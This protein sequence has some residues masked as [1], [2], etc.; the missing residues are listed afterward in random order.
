MG[1]RILAGELEPGKFFSFVG[2]VL[3]LYQPVKQLGR[4]G[5]IAL[6][7]AAAGE[8]IFEILDAPSSV[9]DDR[10]R[11]SCPRSSEASGTRRVSF[12]Y[13]DRPV[14]RD[15]SL[16]LRK[17]EVVALVGA[18]GGGK[19]TVANL[20]AALLGRHRRAD[21]HRRARTSAT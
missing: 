21:H 7:G 8:R 4:V 12:S 17:G 2:A 20:L 15:L 13:G 1:G 5:Q 11:P 3:L 16:E 6:Q 19:T 18:S 10:A 9:P 14:L